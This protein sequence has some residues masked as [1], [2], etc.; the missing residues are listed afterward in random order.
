MI[1]GAFLGA[2]LGIPSGQGWDSQ[3]RGDDILHIA[4]CEGVTIADLSSTDYRP[5]GIKV[6]AKNVPQDIHIH[7][8]RFRDIGVRAIKGSVGQDPKVRAVKG[9]VRYCVFENTKVPPADW[10]F[11]GDYIAAIDMSATPS[12]CWQKP[13]LA[14]RR[15]C[16]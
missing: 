13:N 5:Y 16:G 6:E 8:C 1:L 10:L 4:R 12:D 15:Q 3:A 9:S 2:T 11:G 7:V 14:A